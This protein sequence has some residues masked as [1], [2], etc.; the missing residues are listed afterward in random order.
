MIR[1]IRSFS[2][3]G[4]RLVP[5]LPNYARNNVFA[6]RNSVRNWPRKTETEN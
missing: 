4:A 5:T 2:A 1:K 6:R 3:R